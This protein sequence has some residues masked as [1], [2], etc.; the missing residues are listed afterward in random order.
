[1]LS[2]QEKIRRMMGTF[3]GGS[4]SV[5]T[6]AVVTS[7]QISLQATFLDLKVFQN[8]AYYELEIIENVIIENSSSSEEAPP[9]P[10]PLPTRL[11]VENQWGNFEV[12]LA[13]GLNEGQLSPLRENEN[14]TLS[15]QYQSNLGWS[16]LATET[17]QTAPRLLANVDAFTF[18]G[19]YQ[20]ETIALEMVVSTQVGFR[21]VDR[22]ELTLTQGNQQWIETLTPG[23]TPLRFENLPHLNQ[24]YRVDIQAIIQNQPETIFTKTYASLPF[25]HG[26]YERSFS[27][28]GTLI[29]SPSRLSSTLTHE[30]YTFEV[31]TSSQTFIQDWNGNDTNIV[32]DNLPYDEI[33]VFNWYV[34]FDR[35]SGNETILVSEETLVSI[36]QPTLVLSLFTQDDITTIQLTIDRTY[37]FTSLAL[38]Q[39]Q[40]TLPFEMINENDVARYYE[41]T[42]SEAVEGTWELRGWLDDANPIL[43]QLLV[44][45]L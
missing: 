25:V 17:I 42:T 32:F 6:I 8:S 2:K 1:M 26:N 38:Y 43:Y 45:Q 13:Y 12:T 20:D 33:I 27:S 5:A 4:V 15:I 22:F 9:L 44:V 35:V 41:V 7:F 30:I 34:S 31:V 18:E 11:W 23:M 14:Y 39:Q 24:T 36:G 19:D 10:E 16:T 3:V 28:P 37:A 29:V 21:P 40:R